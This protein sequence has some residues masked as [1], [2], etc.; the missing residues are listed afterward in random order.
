M[1]FR[2]D[3]AMLARLAKSPEAL[4]EVEARAKKVAAA[5]GPG[6]EVSSRIGVNRARASVRA[7]SYSAR[8]RN[9][10]QNILIR[11]LEAGRG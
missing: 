11:A 3:R 4:A 8:R 1:D 7:D 9:S 10:R 5:A 6:F 2:P